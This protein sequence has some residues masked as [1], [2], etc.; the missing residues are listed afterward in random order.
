MLTIPNLATLDQYDSTLTLGPI[1]TTR[2][3]K[4]VVA[5]AA[6]LAQVAALSKSGTLEDW[7]DEVLI[8]PETNSLSGAAGIRFKSAVPGS[9]ARVVAQLY[10]PADPQFGS[11]TPFTGALAASGAVTPAG[12]VGADGWVSTS[13]ILTFV[14][15]DG[16]TFVAGTS[17]D[18]TAIV[19][20][21]ARVKFTQDGT[22]KYFIVTALTAA[23]MTL[24]GGTDYTMTGTAITAVSYSVA[25]V[26]LGFNASSSKWTEF[27]RDA[28]ERD[29]ASPA[30][31]TWYN[32]GSLLLAVP[33]GAWKLSYKADCGHNNAGT[34]KLS[35]STA[36]NAES[37]VDFTTDHAMASTVPHYAQKTIVLAA[38]TTYYLITEILAPG[39]ELSLWIGSGAETFIQAESAYL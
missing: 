23:Q 12:T 29:I 10:F 6:V 15:A 11:G 30:V 37:D 5:N 26:P 25:K 28:T 24:Y 39:G 32:P 33:I 4:Y 36:N 22:T 16:H 14:S 7:G 38:K 1:A 19:P 3:I 2:G 31:S 18:L 17:A 13:T 35:L 21:G 9:P 8:T 34:Q 27:L 20:V